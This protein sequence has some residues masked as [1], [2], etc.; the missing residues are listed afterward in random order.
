MVKWTGKVTH[1]INMGNTKF[2]SRFLY[3]RRHFGV[4]GVDPKIILK[5]NSKKWDIR[6]W[7][8]FLSK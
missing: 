2:M 4:L 8:G 7:T 3:E 5:C 1:V 6:V